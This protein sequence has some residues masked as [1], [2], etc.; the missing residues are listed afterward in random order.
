MAGEISLG[1]RNSSSEASDTFS[2][3]EVSEARCIFFEKNILPGLQ[4]IRSWV[5]EELDTQ[6]KTEP[7]KL[8]DLL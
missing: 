5:F 4:L 6:G 1:A 2:L 7:I 3:L 8:N